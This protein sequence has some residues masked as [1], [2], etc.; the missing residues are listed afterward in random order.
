MPGD[1]SL[2]LASPPSIHYWEQFMKFEFPQPYDLQCC[3]LTWWVILRK[4][5][6][7]QQPCLPLPKAATVAISSQHRPAIESP[8]PFLGPWCPVNIHVCFC[9]LSVQASPFGHT[10][11]VDAARMSWLPPRWLHSSMHVHTHTAE[12]VPYTSVKDVKANWNNICKGP[13]YLLP[14]MNEEITFW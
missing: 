2:D 1:V 3:K 7:R 14:C 12:D 9:R 4:P 13:A 8:Y 6:Q 5:V 10:I 11:F